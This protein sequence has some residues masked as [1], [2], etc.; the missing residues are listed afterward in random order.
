[1]GVLLAA[2]AKKSC[3][4]TFDT[5]CSRG[6]TVGLPSDIGRMVDA[7]DT[8]LL[9]F[10]AW[11]GPTT[12]VAFG[13]NTLV[14]DT[15]ESRVVAGPRFEATGSVLPDLWELIDDT[16]EVPSSVTTSLKG[17]I[18]V[19]PDAAGATAGAVPGLFGA[20]AD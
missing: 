18:G 3:K 17:T 10:G 2:D 14:E 8:L 12:E 16:V 1:M 20:D 11:A 5:V 4:L 13:G 15:E 9:G 7:I 6:R 19:P